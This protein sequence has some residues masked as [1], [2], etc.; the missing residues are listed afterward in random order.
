M[1]I[2][3]IGRPGSIVEKG[4]VVVTTMQNQKSPALPKALPALPSNPTIY[5]VYI[6]RKQWRK[7]ADAIKDSEDQLIIE[8]YPVL[9]KDSQTVAVFAINTTTRNL[10]AARREAQRAAKED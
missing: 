4:S 3:L 2:T 7:V 9:D 8:G 5:T 10:Q 6:A 1:K